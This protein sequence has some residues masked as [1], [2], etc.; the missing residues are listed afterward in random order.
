[1]NIETLPRKCVDRNKDLIVFFLGNSGKSKKY[2][3][4]TEIL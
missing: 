3:E 2:F 4:L 1:M